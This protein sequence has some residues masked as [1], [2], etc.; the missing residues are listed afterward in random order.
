VSARERWLWGAALTFQAALLFLNVARGS[1]TIVIASIAGSA[2]VTL[3]AAWAA[4][5]GAQ[6]LGD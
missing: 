5:L 1:A 6:P 2:S 4:W 3:A